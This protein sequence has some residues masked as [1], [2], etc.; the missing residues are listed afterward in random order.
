M[1]ASEMIHKAGSI[2]CE[3][4]M[5]NPELNP[6]LFMSLTG[7]QLLFL[8]TA[9][10]IY[11]VE[12]QGAL[13]VQAR[14]I[15]SEIDQQGIQLVTS[16]IT[17]AE[18]LVHP[19]RNQRPDLTELFRQTIVNGPRTLFLPLDAGIAESSAE[20]RARYGFL[21]LADSLQLATAISCNCD[22]FLTNDRRLSAI[23]D[24]ACLMV[25]DWD[26]NQG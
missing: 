10:I 26:L 2:A 25:E 5:T 24:I 12:G 6:E 1:F 3:T 21:K 11:L 22:A 20:L 14:S 18:C 8:D 17:L 16:P 13:G 9:P 19:L 7:I 15:F 23:A 4:R